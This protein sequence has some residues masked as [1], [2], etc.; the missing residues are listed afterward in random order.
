LTRI[1]LGYHAKHVTSPQH[2][3]NS[4]ENKLKTQLSNN[5]MSNGKIKKKKKQ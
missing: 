4:I 3:G 5:S 2:R 1:H